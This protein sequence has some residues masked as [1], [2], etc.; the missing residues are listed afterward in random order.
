METVDG[1]SLP[2]ESSI[3]VS[4]DSRWVGSAIETPNGPVTVASI[5]SVDCSAPLT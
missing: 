5:A 2:I 1:S 3:D 4:T